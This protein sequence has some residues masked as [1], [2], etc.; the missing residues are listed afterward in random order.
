M[1]ALFLIGRIILGGFFLMSGLGHL[2][3][4]AAMAPLVAAKGI[5]FPDLAVIVSGLLIVLGGAS[6]MLVAWPRVGIGL[7]IIFLVVVSPIAHN[8]WAASNP[9]ERTDDLGQ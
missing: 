4:H 2:T 9:N 1:K 3:H 7:I 6:I 5:P 8:F